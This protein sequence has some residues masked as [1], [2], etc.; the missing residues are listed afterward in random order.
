[1]SQGDIAKEQTI[2]SQALEIR[3]LQTEIKSLKDA[4]RNAEGDKELLLNKIK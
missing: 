3:E 1:M 4:L 2:Q